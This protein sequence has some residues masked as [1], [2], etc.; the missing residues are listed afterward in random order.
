[1]IPGFNL[2]GAQLSSSAA[3]R[4]ESAATGGA[5]SFGNSG[6][7]LSPIWLLG[8]GAVLLLVVV[9]MIRGR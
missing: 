3:S 5:I 7:S 8:G 6:A 1:M 4:G 9:F 2:P